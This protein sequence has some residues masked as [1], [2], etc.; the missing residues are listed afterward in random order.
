[1]DSKLGDSVKHC[2]KCQEYERLP[3]KAAMHPWEWP[4]R[5]WARIHV[6]YAGPIE[7]KMMLII[8]HAHFNRLEALVVNSAT[9]Q[10]TIEKLCSVFAAHDLLEVVVSDNGSVFTSAEFDEFVRRNIIK[11]LTSAPYHPALFNRLA[12]TAVQTLT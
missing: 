4:N 6:D 5:L 2:S 1:M 9:S 11:H 7:G 12:E 8:M 3:A 10:T